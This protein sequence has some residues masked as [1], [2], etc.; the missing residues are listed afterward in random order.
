[1]HKK[2][3]LEKNRYKKNNIYRMS[4]DIRENADLER[5]GKHKISIK[6]Q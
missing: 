6:N 4:S 3:I 5:Q 2:Q 1:M